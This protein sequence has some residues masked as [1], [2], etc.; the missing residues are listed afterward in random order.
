MNTLSAKQYIQYSRTMLL[1]DIGEAGQLAIINSQVAI[2]GLGGLGQL[3]VQYLA[4][5]GVKQ[6]ILLDH[7]VVA[8]D[9]LPRQLLYNEAD[10]GQYKVTAAKRTLRRLYSDIYFDAIP[11]M[12]TEISISELSDKLSKDVLIFD[13]TDNFA[14]R[15]VINQHCVTQGLTLISAAISAY[16]GQLFCIDFGAKITHEKQHGCYRCLYPLDIETNQTCSQQGVLGPAVGVMASMQALIGL[17]HICNTF[18]QYGML[19]RFDALTLQ[20]HQ[21]KMNR[22]QQ[23]T[24]CQQPQLQEYEH[25]C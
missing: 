3:V 5:A 19:L 6:F 7:D 25:G 1:N 23:C 24:L 8:L 10:I 4:A 13:C 16:H 18:T 21:A 9:N 17:Q 12:L 11:E 2:I 14:S 15:H 22:D 20:W